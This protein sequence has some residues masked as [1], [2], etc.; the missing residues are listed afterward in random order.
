MPSEISV[1]GSGRVLISNPG[2]GVGGG[3]GGELELE[4]DNYLMNSFEFCK[5][6]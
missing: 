2:S 6:V 5:M 4:F 1:L 3:G